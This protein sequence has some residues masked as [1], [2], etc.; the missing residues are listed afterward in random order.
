MAMSSYIRELRALVGPRRLLLPSVSAQV[1]DR[2]GRLLLVRQ[3]ESGVWSTPGGAIEPDERPEEALVRETREETGLEVRATGLADVYGGPEFVVRYA[4]GDETQYVI[5]AYPCEVT[6]GSLRAAD[7]D[8]IDGARYCS[9]AETE[10]LPLTPW[11]RAVL[12][13]VYRAR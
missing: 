2:E 6:G 10:A 8:E 3:A 4:N 11:L 9:R 13:R 7:G 12:D 1:F 5:A